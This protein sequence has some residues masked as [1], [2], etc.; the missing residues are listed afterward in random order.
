MHEVSS[1]FECFFQEDPLGIS[2]IPG[3]F[4]D[5]CAISQNLGSKRY[6]TPLR[7][8]PIR[9]HLVIPLEKIKMTNIVDQLS[10]AEGV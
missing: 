10:A 9:L 2:K 4:V 6:P 8:V 7:E 1:N 5:T 3:S